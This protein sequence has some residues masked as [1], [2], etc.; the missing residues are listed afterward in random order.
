MKKHLSG[1]EKLMDECSQCGIHIEQKSLPRNINAIYYEDEG[2]E[3]VIAISKSLKTQAEQACVIAEE[4]GHFHT[5]C[6]NLLT[7]PSVDRTVIRKQEYAA[8]KWAVQRLVP[9]RQIIRAYEAGCHSLYEMAEHLGA[10][11]EFLAEA[12][13]KYNAVYGKFKASGNYIVYF[14][15]PGIFRIMD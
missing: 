2:T 9:I 13:G 3:P 5:S 4:L 6:G 12:F 11:E 15:P 8:K 10:T 7:D 1:T 14:D